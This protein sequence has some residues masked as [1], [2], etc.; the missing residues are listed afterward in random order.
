VRPQ[1]QVYD[2]AYEP[3]AN[4]LELGREL[5]KKYDIDTQITC[6]TCHR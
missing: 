4:Q 2:I 3:P 5:V 1:D 6:S